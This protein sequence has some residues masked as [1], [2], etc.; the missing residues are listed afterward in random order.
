[1]SQPAGLQKLDE[2]HDSQATENFN[3]VISLGFFLIQFN[4]LSSVY[5]D[6]RDAEVLKYAIKKNMYLDINLDLFATCCE[7]SCLFV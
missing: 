7:N 2:S 4:K 1:M 5:L 3:Q 6:L